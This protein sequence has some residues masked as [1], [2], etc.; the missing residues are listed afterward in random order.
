V[1]GHSGDEGNDGADQLAVNGCQMPELPERD[2]NTARASAENPPSEKKT[3]VVDD[4]ENIDWDAM[5][6]VILSDD[7]FEKEWISERR[8]GDTYC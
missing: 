1:K 8:S 4:I 2:W 6:D 3:H 5:A 7:D